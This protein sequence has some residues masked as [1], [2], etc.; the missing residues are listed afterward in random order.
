MIT[1]LNE[2][3]CKNLLTNNYIGHL[4]YIYRDRPF[5]IPITYFFTVDDTVLGYT[6]EGHK[7]V[8]M[9]KNNSVSLEIDE[10]ENLNNWKSVLAH[11]VYEELSGIDAKAS[12]HEFAEGIKNLASKKEK[13]DFH[14]ISDFSSKLHEEGLPIVFKIAIDEVTGKKRIN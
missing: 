11:G 10:I 8:T 13:K 3:E 12:L 4:A 14:F 9:R 6:N 5:V 2:K 7:T 1:N